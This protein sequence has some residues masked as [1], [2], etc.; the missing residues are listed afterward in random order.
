MP[1]RARLRIAAWRGDR[2][3]FAAV[4]AGLSA[5]PGI[6]EVETSALTGGILIRHTAPFAEIGAAAE[7][8]GLFRVGHAAEAASRP[9]LE[10]PKFPVDPKLAVAAGLGAI[11]LWQLTQGRFL[12]PALTLAWYATRVA[13]LAA[14][15]RSLDDTQ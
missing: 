14:G 10:W 7:K 6:S 1:G 13:G 2:P 11:A 3:F 8:A 5:H 9:P 4:A 12:P 15:G